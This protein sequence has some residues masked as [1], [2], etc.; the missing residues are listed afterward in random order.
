MI[1][2]ILIHTNN[3]PHL[4]TC[5]PSIILFSVWGMTSSLMNSLGVKDCK[6]CRQVNITSIIPVVLGIISDIDLLHWSIL[7][8]YNPLWKNFPLKILCADD[9]GTGVFSVAGE[10]SSFM[11]ISPYVHNLITSISCRIPLFSIF[12]AKSIYLCTFKYYIPYFSYYNSK[13]C[14]IGTSWVTFQYLWT[15]WNS[16]LVKF[17]HKKH[18]IFQALNQCL[19]LHPQYL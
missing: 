13:K 3:S 18:V 9:S 2:H 1:N 6:I 7:L 8:W 11:V 19:P 14:Y 12:F 16:T 15:A 4:T 17:G 10:L 5:S